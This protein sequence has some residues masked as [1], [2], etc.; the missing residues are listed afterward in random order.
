M[1]LADRT[2]SVYLTEY[3]SYYPDS[4][5]DLKVEYKFAVS[6]ALLAVDFAAY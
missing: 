4:P 3:C 1:N 2:L 6:A 5:V